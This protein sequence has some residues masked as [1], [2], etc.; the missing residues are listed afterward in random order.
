MISSV[1]TLGNGAN[2]GP[3]NMGKAA[4]EALALT[5]AKEERG[6]GIRTNIVAPSLTVTEM[7]KRLSQGHLRRRRHPRAGR[8]LP[9]RPGQHAR[10][11]RRGGDLPGLVGQP[12]RQRPEDQRQRRRLTVRPPP[13]MDA[14]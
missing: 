3:Y 1:A 2:G 4:M 11:R 6:H 10:G 13:F 9:V 8:P 7:G 12:L 5:L 14:N